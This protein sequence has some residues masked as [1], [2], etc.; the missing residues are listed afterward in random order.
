MAYNTFPRKG[1][2]R[3][4]VEKEEDIQKVRDII[5]RMD[6]FEYEY[7]PD[8]LIAVFTKDVRTFSDGTKHLWLDMAYTHKF[9]SLNLNELLVRCWADGVKVFIVEGGS[10]DYESYDTWEDN[11]Q[12]M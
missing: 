7:L 5:H 12:Q 1:Y 8:D 11:D 3:I 2:G 10:L 4:F 6:D 9:D